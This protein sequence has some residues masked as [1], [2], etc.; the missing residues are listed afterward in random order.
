MAGARDPTAENPQGVHQA[1]DFSSG[2]ADPE[3]ASSPGQ[4]YSDPA[5]GQSASR[6]KTSHEPPARPPGGLSQLPELMGPALFTVLPRFHSI[7]SRC[8]D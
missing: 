6:R 7:R 4:S 5:W 2:D 3:C 1:P 8:V